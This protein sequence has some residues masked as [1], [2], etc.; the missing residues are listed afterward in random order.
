M[1]SIRRRTLLGG[2][3]GAAAAMTLGTRP[4]RA[5]DSDLT[6]WSRRAILG[7]GTALEAAAAPV[8]S[9][10]YTRL[11][12]G[13]GYPLT[14]RTDLCPAQAKRDDTRTARASIV[15]FTDVHVVDAQ[16][17]VRFEWL[18]QITGSAFRPHE[19]LGTQGGAQLVRRVNELG[20]GPFSGRAFD[21]VV[22][23]GDSSD[24]H[25]RVE[26]DWFLAMM[27]GGAITANTGSPTEW[28]GV[29]NAGDSLYYLP[30]STASDTYKKVGF[31]TLPGFFERATTPHTSE[32]LKTEWFSVFGNHDDSIE[33]TLPSGT[34]ILADMYTGGFKFTGFD[35]TSANL[36]LRRSSI[37]GQSAIP[38]SSSLAKSRWEITPDERRATFTPRE[39]MAAHLDPKVDGPGP[40]GHGF[41][42]DA[43][44]DGVGY[45]SFQIAQG[46]VGI[47]MDSTNRAGFTDGSI[48]DEQFRWIKRTIEAS[49][50]RYY[51]GWGIEHRTDRSDQLFVLFSHH[52]SDSMNNL[53]LA[54]DKLEI[55]HSGSELV[56]SL[57]RY[58]NVVAWVNGHTHDNKITPHHHNDPTRSFWEINTAS[59]VD[60]PQHT[61]II[62]VCD[63]ADGTLSLFTTLIE[64]AAPYQAAYDDGSPSALAS[65]YR[66]LSYNDIHRDPNRI[67][68][69]ADRN[70]EL[71]LKNPMA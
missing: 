8:G 59:H 13:P 28:E 56:S 55:R 69:A 37:G 17:P 4:A 62:D 57:Q 6:S 64:S 5:A 16:S 30:E 52:T 9:S 50:S 63:N 41:T 35:D 40:H 11:T 29:Q 39:F 42:A 25:E 19:A 53:L 18:H 3:I 10:G 58:P 54:P 48:G 7:E 20:K 43:V 31:P 2:G 26:L 51:D 21:C 70:T 22:T 49:S 15:Q 65:L 38:K 34:P 23:T 1:T 32:G 33:G 61:R 12:S 45:Y 47:S 36:A 24:N 66:E 71:L 14:V 44:A 27:S 68:T 46:V 67:G 60:F